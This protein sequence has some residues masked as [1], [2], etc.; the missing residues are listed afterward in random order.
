MHHRRRVP[1]VILDSEIVP[2]TSL[3]KRNLSY[4]ECR[5]IAFQRG[6][7]NMQYVICNVPYAIYNKCVG[8]VSR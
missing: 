6:W 5:S 7:S 8:E 1:C 2:H 3:N 4:A